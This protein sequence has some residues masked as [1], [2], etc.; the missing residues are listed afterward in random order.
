MPRDIPLLKEEIRQTKG[1]LHKRE[2]DIPFAKRYCIDKQISFLS[3]YKIEKGSLK[4]VNGKLYNPRMASF[5]IEIYKPSFNAKDNKIICVGLYNEDK[6]II[7]TWKKSKCKEVIVLK[8]EREMLKKFFELIKEF[9]ILVSY[10]GDNFDL[11]FLKIRAEELKLE[12][13][14]ILSRT[15]GNLKELLHIDLYKIITKHLA[16]EVKT[17]T[18][19][20][21]EVAKF[22]LGE[23]KGDLKIKESKEIWD[24][25]ETPKIDKIL[26]YNLQDCKITYL[27]GEKVLPLEYRFSNLIG[28]SLFDVTRSGFS[29]L[30][31]NYLMREAV[32]KKILIKN[33]PT[34]KELE[35]RRRETY[36]GAYVHKPIPGLYENIHVLDFKSL[37]PSILVSH[38]IS[39]DTLDKN[40]KLEIRING[41]TNIFTKERKGFLVGVIED[42]VKRRTEIKENLGKGVDE[43][44]LKTLANATYGYLGFFAA[45]W[46]SKECAES[47]TALGRRYITDTIKKAEEKGFEVIYG[48]TDSLMIT[49]N[50]KN[51]QR[52]LDYINKKLPGIMELEYEGFYKRGIF[53]STATGGAKKRYAL[54]DEKGNIEIKGF[55]FVRG[56]WSKI[57]KEAQEKVLEFVLNNKEKEAVKFVNEVIR[58]IK[59]GGIDK[60]KLVISRQLTKDL[61]SY[62]QIAPHVKV[63]RDLK[64]R[65]IQISRGLIIQYII[66]RE[67]KSIS[68]KAR[69]FEEAKNYDS[70]YYI[71]NQVIPAALRILSILGY[72]ENDFL[73]E[74]KNLAGF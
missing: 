1:I 6:K 65:G 10:N 20:L 38:N 55:E 27:I 63:A 48:D 66:T 51:I 59:K 46:Y 3:P 25:D 11:P 54:I 61:E 2:Y 14:V 60:E 29:Q 9:D 22:F 23:G 43:Y 18:N 70:G 28:I 58:K 53:V 69:W 57:A 26:N 24:S 64:K 42:L 19:K 8:D 45:R 35:Q 47:I 40:G 41:K 4:K 71:N 50:A 12:H 32:R 74:Q 36:I 17:V 62:T 56:D 7:L 52:F 13:P 33:N 39:P 44:A 30:V 68:E 67:G 31:E 73:N 15:R 37:Y 21:D 16:A 5:D 34:D 72:S 49:G